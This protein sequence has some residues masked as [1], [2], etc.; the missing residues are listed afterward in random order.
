LPGIGKFSYSFGMQRL[1]PGMNV[2]A[3]A[4][5]I[6]SGLLTLTNARGGTIALTGATVINPGDGQV[7]PGATIFIDGNEIAAVGAPN[8]VK[9]PEGARRIDCRG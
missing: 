8:D 5:L 4:I 1:L 9:I 2:R 7:L 3:G 6:L